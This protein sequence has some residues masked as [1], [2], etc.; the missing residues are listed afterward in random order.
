M[1]STDDSAPAYSP[2]FGVMG[3]AS[4]IVFSGEFRLFAHRQPRDLARSLARSFATSTL[5]R[6]RVS[7]CVLVRLRA[8][9]SST[10]HIKT[11]VVIH[12]HR[13]RRRHR[14]R[15]HRR[16]YIHGAPI[17]SSRAIFSRGIRRTRKIACVRRARI[18]DPRREKKRGGELVLYGAYA[19]TGLSSA[20]DVMCRETRDEPR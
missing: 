18:I 2:F 20:G 8:S 14:R 4:A 9:R 15:R 7:S 17:K 3:A 11:D 10:S 5:T 12:R 6:P 1:S 16:R 13:L 19:T